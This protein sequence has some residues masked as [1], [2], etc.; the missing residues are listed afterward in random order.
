MAYRLRKNGRQFVA[1]AAARHEY[2]GSRLND[3]LV[4][5]ARPE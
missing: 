1:I 2:L 3:A 4:A 5:Y